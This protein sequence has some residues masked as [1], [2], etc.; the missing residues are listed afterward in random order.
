MLAAAGAAHVARRLAALEG[1]LPADG[2][3]FCAAY[4][5]WRRWRRTV[6]HAESPADIA[7]QVPTAIQAVASLEQLQP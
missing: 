1:R 3:V 2:A 5:L 7:P 4:D 6:A